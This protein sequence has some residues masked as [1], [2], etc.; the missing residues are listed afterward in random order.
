[1][2]KGAPQGIINS[3]FRTWT[4][5]WVTSRRRTVYA[6]CRFC[7]E[8]NTEDSIE[9]IAVCGVTHSLANTFL[10]IN[11]SPRSISSF[12]LLSPNNPT[13]LALQAVHLH[14]TYNTYNYIRHNINIVNNHQQHIYHTY[15]AILLNNL[16]SSPWARKLRMYTNI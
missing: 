12:I 3:V 14:V 4:N 13:H 8:W 5:A 11:N 7:Q 9:H 6:R 1:M 15:R 16:I 2:L 10:N